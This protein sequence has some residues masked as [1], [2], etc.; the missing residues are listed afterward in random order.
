MYSTPVCT[1]IHV[2]SIMYIH[3]HV[4]TCMV[5]YVHVH[6]HVHVAVLKFECLFPVKKSVTCCTIVSCKMA[7]VP[8]ANCA[9]LLEALAGVY[10]VGSNKTLTYRIAPV[11]HPHRT[12]TAPELHVYRTTTI[13][14]G[15]PVMGLHRTVT[16]PQ[17]NLHTTLSEPSPYFSPH[18]QRT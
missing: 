11:P 9:E 7:I 10:T 3:V 16:E 1:L 5:C 13:P 12:R 8:S 15:V 6:V 4:R 18:C 2:Q 17:P 14:N